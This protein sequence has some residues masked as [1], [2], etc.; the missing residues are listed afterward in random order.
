MPHQKDGIKFIEKH[1]GRVLLADDMGLGKSFT[2]LG[3]LYR[4]PDMFPAVV[5]CPA[6]V[7]FNWEHEAQHHFGYRA[8][9]CEGEAA[10]NLTDRAGIP[11]LTIINYDI[12]APRR[13]DD[14]VVK[15]K[16]WTD[17]L[18][19]LKPKTLI[20]DECQMLGGR[21]TKRTK[22]IT[23][24]S[25]EFKHIIAMSGTPIVNRPIELFPILRILWPREFRSFWEYAQRYCNPKLKPWGWEYKGATNLDEL[26]NRLRR[27]G[28]LRRTE[29]IL[30][31][32]NKKTSITVMPMKDS[33]QYHMAENDFLAWARKHKADRVHSIKKAEAVS[34]VGYLLRLAAELK[35]DSCVDWANKFL[36]ENPKEKLVLFAFHKP[37]IKRLTKEIP[38]KSIVIDGTVTG[39]VRQEAVWQFQKDPQTRLCVAQLKA[40]GVGINLTAAATL[41]HVELWHNP[42]THNQASKRIHRIGQKSDTNIHYLI[43]QG[44]IEER[45][46]KLLQKRQEIIAAIIDGGDSPKDFNIYQE[47][48]SALGKGAFS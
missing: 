23:K 34:K 35:M 29:G 17:Y 26:H 19:Q 28:M 44:S 31:L 7:K 39:R 36:D 20:L 1:H 2:S 32:P 42:A 6:G 10:P 15:I 12:L 16:P 46:C 47:L 8:S 38:V 48:V 30:N 9:I 14:R 22:A 25:K 27:L 18:R 41:A 5:V 37:V 43:A 3:V 40:A 13:K 4:N 11:Q 24:L 33:S 21:A 45:L